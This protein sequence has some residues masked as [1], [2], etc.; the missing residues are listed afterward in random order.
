MSL[1][2]E[3]P[4]PAAPLTG[5]L[6]H[7]P[8]RIV[9]EEKISRGASNICYAVRVYT[10]ES[11]TVGKPMILKE[12]YPISNDEEFYTT[13]DA[14]QQ[15]HFLFSREDS[16]IRLKE[17]VRRQ[18]EAVKNAY[19]LQETLSN[20]RQTTGV[21]VYPIAAWGDE[22]QLTYYTLHKAD[23]G[24]SLE[25]E[26]PKNLREI[27]RVMYSAADS[28]AR[29]N[30]QGY[31]HGDLK[32]ENLLWVDRGTAS[33]HIV[34]FDFDCSFDYKNR[35]Y[36]DI[37]RCT[38]GYTAPELRSDRNNPRAVFRPSLDVYALG[39]ILFRL[40]FDGDYPTEADEN[41]R[42]PEDAPLASRLKEKCNTNKDWRGMLSEQQ[43]RQLAAILWR[44]IRNERDPRFLG[45]YGSPSALAAALGD[46]L[47]NLGIRQLPA[48]HVSRASY[49]MLSAEIIDK[50]PLYRYKKA[51]TP[52]LD[53]VLAGI[54]PMRDAFLEHLL[55]A[56]QMLDTTLRVH[57]ISPHVQDYLNQI[58]CTYP[59]LGKVVNMTLDDK[60]YCGEHYAPDD[61]SIVTEKLAELYFCDAPATADGISACLNG[62][63]A[64]YYLLVDTDTDQN[65]LAA[66][67]LAA[68]R[69]ASAF[70][71]YTD[72]R[73]DGFGL[74]DLSKPDTSP[75]GCN[76]RFSVSE[77]AFQ[78]SI[79]ER[80]FQ[81]HRHYSDANADEQRLRQEFLASDAYN[82]SSSIRAALSLSYEAFSIGCDLKQK[83]GIQTWNLRISEKGEAY[84][85]LLWLE[86]RAWCAFMVMQGY[87]QP[88]REQIRAYA[89]RNDNDQKNT[90]EKLHPCLC[91]S[92]ANGLELPPPEHPDWDSEAAESQYDPLDRF[93][94][95]F[96]RL[97]ADKCTSTNMQP[98]LIAMAAYAE[99][100]KEKA[101]VSALQNACAAMLSGTNKLWDDLQPPALSSDTLAKL[102]DALTA[103]SKFL[104]EYN[105]YR[106][107][108][109]SDED[110][111]KAASVIFQKN[112]FCS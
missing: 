48:D 56:C 69:T 98:L 21:T 64:D 35:K 81:V 92:R 104:H 28:V 3:L 75:I 83:Q 17:A 5:Q 80:A 2:D 79:V 8:Y 73:G 23:W 52:F 87:T 40:I 14:Q 82:Q 15:L 43:Q 45:R 6:V 29:M 72:G 106:D 1:Y 105:R 93:S 55:S 62:A 67:Q 9:V 112:N 51:D 103:E 65:Y 24:D 97:C 109:K 44:S 46:L 41:S 36:P 86:H 25:K 49:T 70:I 94:L 111:L 85:R 18:R 10:G 61:T 20:N 47:D 53:V 31:V 60:P 100:D 95:F 37:P 32:P 30:A 74:R 33:S 89:F 50:Y 99:T 78:S 22:E 91:P 42:S 7:E 96:H 59:A 4:T 12:F 84:R 107:F 77:Q 88:S 68:Q 102:F 101:F 27:L 34:L 57:I 76:E 16:E 66:E 108:K 90:R 63:E 11:D 71:G 110:I 26:P 19:A 13:R 54:S 58:L 39:C 38:P